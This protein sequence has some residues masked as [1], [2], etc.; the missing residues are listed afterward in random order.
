[1]R[2]SWKA[3][4]IAGVELRVHATFLILLAWAALAAYRE[5]GS[6]EGAVRGVVLTLALFASVVLHE[7][8]HALTARHYGVQTRD[9]TLLPIGGVAS[10]SHIPKEPRQELLISLAG[11]AVTLGIIVVLS[12]ALRLLGISAVAATESALNNR[13]GLLSQ[14]MWANMTLL[15]FNLLPA[16]P[17]DGGRVLRAGLALRMDYTRA[18]G[19][20]V[21]VGKTFA[22]FFA[23]VGF[24][25]NP[26]LVLIGLFVW[27]AAAG[28]AA[29]VMRRSVL[30][31][32][33]VERVMIRDVQTLTPHDT[34]SVALDHV[35][36]G[37]Q[38]DFPVVERGRVMGVLTRAKL[39]EVLAK[40]GPEAPVGEAMETAFRTADAHEPLE[41]ALAR[42]Q[43]C[44]CQALPVLS[45]HRLDGVL[46]LEN[47]GEFVM[48]EAAL[49]AAAATQATPSMSVAVAG[50]RHPNSSDTD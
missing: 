22:L 26:F 46:T 40:R 25:F 31:G 16:F 48:I 18:T 1:M 6:A 28:E 47:V 42:L 19:L 29:E 17:M 37:F 20:A 38:Q 13:G 15:V 23:I 49:R 14:L 3:G 12:T 5:S 33:P 27:L 50:A 21:R 8:G 44:R 10:L 9:I 43:E 39:F 32:V 24:F 30:E 34:L 36:R 2:W 41:N 45:D 35:L 7:L 11:P 4:R